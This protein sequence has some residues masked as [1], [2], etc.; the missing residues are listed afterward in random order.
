MSGLMFEQLAKAPTGVVLCERACVCL[1]SAFYDTPRL[2][3]LLRTSVP[4][5]TLTRHL[6]TLLR[7][8]S[9]KKP[10]QNLLGNIL[11]HDPLIGLV[12]Q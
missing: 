2:R 7:S 4:T 8:T 1:L 3:T 6:G 12:T 5:E 10:S 11:L 9:F